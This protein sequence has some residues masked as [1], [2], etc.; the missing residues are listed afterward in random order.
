MKVMYPMSRVKAARFLGL[1]VLVTAAGAGVLKA[2]FQYADDFTA[3][4]AETDS[5]RHSAFWSRE[6][7]PLPEPYLSYLEINRNRGLAFLDHKGQPAE[8]AYRF[9]LDS[10]TVQRVVTGVLVVD[11]SFPSAQISQSPPGWLQFSLSTDGVSWSTPEELYAGH[12]VIPLGSPSGICHV[13]FSGARVVIDNLSI[14]LQSAAVTI[15][16]PQNFPTIQ[17][18]I[19]AAHNGD[20]IE[21]ARGIYSGQG[22]RDI[23]FSG[24]AITVCSAAG[25]AETIIDCGGSAA[26][27]DG[28]HRGFYFHQSE[29]ADSVLSGFTVRGGRI[30]G[31]ENPPDPAHWN[32]GR[33]HP[34]GGGI[35]C[36]FS[37]PTI[38]DCVIQD[39]GTEI[40]GGIGG[41]GTE[42]L[43]TDCVIEECVAGGYDSAQSGGRGGAIGLIGGSS[44]TI[45]N[46]VIQNNSGYSNSYGAGLYVRQSSAVVAGCS[47]SGNGPS[48]D[49]PGSLQG[50]G[51]YCSGTGTE[52]TFRNCI[53]S[54][55][56]ADVGAG[57]YLEWLPDTSVPPAQRLPR[58]RVE[59]INCTIVGNVR[60]GPVKSPPPAAGIQS[61]S[62]DILVISSILWANT[63][64]ALTITDAV[65]PTP[66]TYCDVEGGYPGTGN[67]NQNP[68]FADMEDGDYHLKS[69]YGRY[70]PWSGRWVGDSVHSPCIDAGDPE[71]S[72]G[73]EPVQNGGRINMGGYGGT[74]EASNGAGHLIYHVDGSSGR[75]NWN[76]G[77][78][79]AHAFATIQQA[80]DTA[81]DG[82]TIVVWPGVYRE[83]LFFMGKAITVQSAADA[84]VLTA[85]GDYAVSF[86][87]CEGPGSVLA[88]FVITGCG[89]AA[90]FCEGASPS[91]RNLTIVG[92]RFG[93]V[94]GDGADPN[95]TNCILWDN[96]DGDLSECTARYS[97]IQHGV[98]EKKLGNI[99]AEPLFADPQKGD[100][101]LKSEWGRYV[102][103]LGTWVADDKTSPCIDAGNP[104]DDYS[105]ERMPNGDRIDMGAYGGTPFASL[106]S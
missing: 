77:L 72:V 37:S 82:D 84:A 43:I 29:G 70:D 32:P 56:R 19:N 14:L 15:R 6:F 85:P 21:V 55:N 22:N 53:F 71:A 91:L 104:E 9:P 48:D 35:Y 12:H 106:S 81:R 31:F 39:C 96:Q 33:S 54:D 57:L 90:I 83:Q 64:T 41:V 75:D 47:I 86:Y 67:I 60:S 45:T 23:D 16:V 38:V 78:S 97:D 17:A 59:V 50:A 52:V 36:E 58:C 1:C 61:A 66:V 95:I 73:D 79:R 63:K 88:N 102:P 105:G 4:R 92:N 101:H 62:V 76:D 27:S 69:K 24:K 99:R 30:F 10:A 7:S 65:S 25:S 28:G 94:A 34:I 20:V 3:D 18:A 8:L 11:V 51:A 42:A 26:V 68:L 100:Y 5:Y 74:S 49:A 2:D 89:V 80:I 13:L 40:G 44:A 103:Q 98:P 46:C 93:V 87:Y